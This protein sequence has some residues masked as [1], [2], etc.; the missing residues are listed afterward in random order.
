[1]K[2]FVPNNNGSP[3]FTISNIMGLAL[4]NIYY[5]FYINTSVRLI[6]YPL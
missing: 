4:W 3:Y 5:Y 1:M 2:N 6:S